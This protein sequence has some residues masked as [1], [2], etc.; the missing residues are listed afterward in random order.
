[1]SRAN[2]YIKLYQFGGKKYSAFSIITFSNV[3][4]SLGIPRSDLNIFG[5][6]QWSENPPQF[7]SVPLAVHQATSLSGGRGKKALL[8]LSHFSIIVTT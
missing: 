6:G 3:T 5:I 2:I 1:M 8:K 4:S 7:I